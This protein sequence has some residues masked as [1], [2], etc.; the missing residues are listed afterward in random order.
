MRRLRSFLEHPLTKGLDLDDPA[1]TLL[2]LHIIKNKPFLRSIYIEWYHQ[3]INFTKDIEKPILELGSGAGF[4]KELRPAVITSD[5]LCVPA[6]EL[7]CDAQNLPFHSQSLG[8]I[9]MTNVLHHISNPRHFFSESLRCIDFGGIIAMIEPWRTPWSEFVYTHLHYESYDATS[10]SWEFI[11][12]KPLSVSNNALA[13]IIF[14]RDIA[15][16][17]REFPCWEILHIQPMMPFVYLLSGGVSLKSLA[18]SW[19]YAAIRAIE[20]RLS[21]FLDHLAMFAMIVL[22]KTCSPSNPV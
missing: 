5:I 17:R 21:Y 3:L 2:R 19:T 13:W 6:V 8:G 18:P 16:F 20:K 14:H 15:Q 1:T 10:P 12:G 22:K 4:L 7:V 9:M 11:S